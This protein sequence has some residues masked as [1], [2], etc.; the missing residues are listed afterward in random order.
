MDDRDLSMPTAHL[1]IQLYKHESTTAFNRLL[2]CVKANAE[3]DYINTITI[4]SEWGNHSLNDPKIKI[5]EAAR[6]ATFTDLLR[7]S[8][9][10]PSPSSSHIILANSDI[11]LTPDVGLLLKEIQTPT[12]VAAITRRELNGE[13]LHLP[14]ES[15]DCWVFK[16]HQPANRLFDACEFQLGIAG[17]ENVFATSL[18][19]HGYDLYNPCLDCR[20]VHND[21]NP[22]SSFEERYYGF[23]WYVAPC[24]TADIRNSPPVGHPALARRP[25]EEG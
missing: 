1:I 10:H 9:T 17:C 4:W 2:D 8:I 22:S 7:L 3:L 24:K 15:Q 6:R 23:Y 18:I 16:S 25:F 14:E 5:V 19:T 21:D 11:I 13:F 20:I 12:H